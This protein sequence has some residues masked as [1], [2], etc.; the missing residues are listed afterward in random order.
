L[1]AVGRWNVMSREQRR[2]YVQDLLAP[3]RTPEDLLAEL[4]EV[5]AAPAPT[6]PATDSPANDR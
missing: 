3:L 6:P 5:Q 4:V 1:L 2:A